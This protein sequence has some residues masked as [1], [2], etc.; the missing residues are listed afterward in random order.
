MQPTKRNSAFGW[1]HRPRERS[2]RTSPCLPSLLECAQV[3]AQFFT[4]FSIPRSRP[5]VLPPTARSFVA[6]ALGRGGRGSWFISAR[7]AERAGG[8]D[9]DDEDCRSRRQFAILNHRLSGWHPLPSYS[10]SAL[11]RTMSSVCRLYPINPPRDKQAFTNAKIDTSPAHRRAGINVAVE[12]NKKLHGSIIV[13]TLRAR[14]RARLLRRKNISGC[15][16]AT[17]PVVREAV[18]VRVSWSE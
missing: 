14:A 4:D 8:G 12:G 18:R 15:E 10:M 11:S 9:E 3:A 17:S 7:S 16:D 5:A 1:L 6:L 13:A 2:P